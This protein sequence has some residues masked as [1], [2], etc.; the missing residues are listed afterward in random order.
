MRKAAL[1]T[2]SLCLLLL[3][4]GIGFRL[5]GFPGGGLFTVLACGI[6]TALALPLY[7]FSLRAEGIGRKRKIA[8][9]TGLLF[10]MLLIVA[11]LFLA[12]RWEG[13]FSILMAAGILG[14]FYVIMQLDLKKLSDEKINHLRGFHGI[15]LGMVGVLLVVPIVRKD[16][17]AESRRQL[18]VLEAE[19]QRYDSIHA[20]V[21]REYLLVYN[22]TSLNDSAREVIRTFFLS[23]Q[24]RLSSIIEIEEDFVYQ[25]NYGISAWKETGFNYRE[26]LLA[27][28]DQQWTAIYFVGPNI[29][30]PMGK[31]VDIYNIARAYRDADLHPSVPFVVPV[32]ASDEQQVQWV[33]DNFYKATAAEARMR[34]CLLRQNILQSVR[35]SLGHKL[36]KET[37]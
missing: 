10:G 4:T 29:Q 1:I 9:L 30:M 11:L 20:V 16:N 19:D 34:I 17:T 22:D 25:L 5:V 26:A 35:Y 27:P 32:N 21:D 8:A 33:K 6:F 2:G 24:S 37:T 31:A 3:V 12:Q 15:F 23:A 14:L 36:Y 13:W 28:M 18:A 7:Y